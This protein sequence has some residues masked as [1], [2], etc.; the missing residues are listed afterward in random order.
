MPLLNTR[1][2]ALCRRA[3]PSGGGHARNMS[4]R[5][6][7]TDIDPRP[8]PQ[9]S[10]ARAS[11]IVALLVDP[12][13]LDDRSDSESTRTTH[14]EYGIELADEN[15]SHDPERSA[16][17]GHVDARH[18][19]QAHALHVQNVWRRGRAGRRRSTKNWKQNGTQT[20]SGSLSMVG[21]AGTTPATVCAAPSMR[22]V[23]QFVFFF[24]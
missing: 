16:R 5:G 9:R 21:T 11:L 10:R 1:S 2:T 3:V 22:S 23:C 13:G 17:L 24:Y 6:R 12:L 7:P 18:A 20:V 4:G 8:C 19:K 15:V 14:I